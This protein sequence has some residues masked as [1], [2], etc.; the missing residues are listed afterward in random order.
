MATVNKIEIAG[1]EGNTMAEPRVFAHAA[2]G[3][4]LPT[5]TDP[6]TVNDFVYV[7]PNTGTTPSTGDV[8]I[9]QTRGACIYI[10]GSGSLDVELESGD[11][12]IFKGVTAGSFL[13]ILV[14]KVFSTDAAGNPSTSATDIIALF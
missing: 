1:L 3:I 6:V 10:G 4:T 5:A 7:V 12:V 8:Q 9:V 13:P 2:K 14:T 11:R